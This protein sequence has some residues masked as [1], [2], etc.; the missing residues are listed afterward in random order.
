MKNSI[1][2]LE[3][4]IDGKT[5]EII[6]I[7]ANDMYIVTPCIEDKNIQYKLLEKIKLDSEYKIHQT[8]PEKVKSSKA[9]I[10]KALIISKST[11]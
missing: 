10:S 5:F 6:H 9:N 4:T 11:K 8:N 7:I 2:T 3:F 1:N